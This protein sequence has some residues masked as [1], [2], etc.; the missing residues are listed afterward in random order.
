MSDKA[1]YAVKILRQYAEET[2]V[3]P[4]ST[5]DLSPLETWLLVQMFLKDKDNNITPTE[6]K[7]C[8]HHCGFSRSMDQPYSRKCLYC[9][10]EES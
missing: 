2:L 1:K 8:E 9:G 4:R 6:I 3:L 5:S 7:K 10:S